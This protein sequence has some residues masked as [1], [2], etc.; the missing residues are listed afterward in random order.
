MAADFT[1]AQYGA[2]EVLAG[3]KKNQITGI[4]PANLTAFTAKV[5]DSKVTLSW[6]APATTVVDS[7]VLC[8]TKGVMIRRKTGSYP[9]GLTDGDLVID[10]STLSGSHEDTGLTNDTTY[11][12]RAFAYSDHGVYN[13]NEANEVTCTPKAYI[14]YGFKIKKAESAPAT[15]VEYT[16]MAVGL[17]PAAVNLTTGVMDLGGWSD[18]WFVTENKPVMLKSD[19]TEDYELDPDDYTK[20]SDGTTASDV[21]NTSYNGNAMARIPLV[22]M[23][24]WD[25]DTYIYCNICNIQLDATYHAYAHTRADG[26]VAGKVYIAMFEGA[27][28]GSKLRSLKGLTPINSQT[29]ATEISYATAN[30]SHWNTGTWSQRNL[31]NM[32]LILLGKTTNTQAAFGYGHYSGG[33][34]ASSLLTTGTL[35]DKGQFYGTSGNIAMKAFH[36]ENWYGDRWDRIVGLVTNGSTQILANMTPEVAY[37]SSGTGYV[38][39]GIVPS[40]T[41][42]GYI[43]ADDADNTFGM[44]PKTA[45][46]SDSTYDCDGLWFA[47]SCYA[48]VGGGCGHGLRVGAF[49]VNLGAAFSGTDWDVG[50]SLSCEQPAGA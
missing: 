29:G 35:S 24:Q 41:S 37:N 11:Y 42:G 47:A 23:K 14:L 21:A 46:G 10:T 25:D 43:S 30:G 34:A 26:S 17:T 44:I 15:R 13:L 38:N 39:T 9:T 48:R 16:E 27:S 50:A 28:S 40:G 19:G 5:G 2:D 22:W 8:T 12:Y 36:I 49:A 1:G 31:I 4:P 45:S 32:L 7:Q 20:K 6:T 33:S 3:I 18:A